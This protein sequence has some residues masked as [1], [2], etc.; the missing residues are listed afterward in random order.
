MPATRACRVG[1]SRQ[2]AENMSTASALG[3]D[4]DACIVLHEL[5]IK[6]KIMKIE[7]LT[8]ASYCMSF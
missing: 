5:W 6:I 8:L 7:I 4:Y 3:Q 2:Q 1:T